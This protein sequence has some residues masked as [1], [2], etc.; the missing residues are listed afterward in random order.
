MHTSSLSLC[1]RWH[2]NYLAAQYFKIH[3]KTLHTEWEGALP[4]SWVGGV[5]GFIRGNCREF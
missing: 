4:R 5:Y 1:L 2:I 3:F